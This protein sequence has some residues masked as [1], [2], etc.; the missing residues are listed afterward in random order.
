MLLHVDSNCFLEASKA[1][2]DE[3]NS[4]SKVEL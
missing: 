3:D 1:A 2:A 4:C